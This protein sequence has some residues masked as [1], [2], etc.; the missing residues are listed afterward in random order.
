M[1]R[2]VCV[3]ATQ[4]SNGLRLAALI[5]IGTYWSPDIAERGFHSQAGWLAF[6]G[7]ALGL[8]AV[9]VRWN[10]FGRPDE[11]LPSVPL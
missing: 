9:S 4:T 5:L 7:V 3:A 8:V 6:N 2:S 11:V 1:P 10:M